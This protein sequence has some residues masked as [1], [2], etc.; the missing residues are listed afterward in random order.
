VIPQDICQFDFETRPPMITH[1]CAGLRGQYHPVEDI[2]NKEETHFGTPVYDD[3]LLIRIYC[4]TFNDLMPDQ[5]M[6]G[7]TALFWV[8]TCI[9]Q[10]II[11]FLLYNN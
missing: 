1:F 7:L 10:L 6:V 9:L 2:W 11:F 3:L 4:D 5:P 8:S